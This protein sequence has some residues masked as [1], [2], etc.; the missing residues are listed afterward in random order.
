MSLNGHPRE[1]APYRALMDLVK[2]TGLLKKAGD[3]FFKPYGLTQ[4]Q[5]NVLMVLKH[6][7]VKGCTQ[8]ELSRRLLVNRADMSGLVRRMAKRKLLD[9]D[10]TPGDERAWQVSISTGGRALLQKIEP[11]YYQKVGRVMGVH[12]VAESRALSDLLGRTQEAMHKHAF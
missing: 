10:D 8:S 12:T 11:T 6:D 4:S 7:A 5:F 3:H 2:V 1:Q 9:R